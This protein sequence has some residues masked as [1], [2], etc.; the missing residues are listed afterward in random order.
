[1]LGWAYCDKCGGRVTGYMPWVGCSCQPV[2]ARTLS[3]YRK[4]AGCPRGCTGV[5]WCGGKVALVL[6][7]D[8][9]VALWNED[10]RRTER[11]GRRC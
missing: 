5:F 9:S 10:L 3:S 4:R 7:I 8:G 11:K 1:M 6:Q 2:S